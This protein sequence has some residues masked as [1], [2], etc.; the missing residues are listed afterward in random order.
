MRIG[1]RLWWLA[2][3]SAYALYGQEEL[4]T[5][6]GVVTD[7]AQGVMPGVTVTV[8]N[9]DTNISHA[10]VTNES[11]YFTVT[12]LPPGAYELSASKTGFAA[13]RQTG[14]VLE[15]G[16]TLR[17]DV[18]LEVGSVAETVTVR[19]DPAPLNTENGAIKG[20]VIVY[21]EIQDM[22][23]NGRNFTDLTYTVPG[24]V[25]NAQGGSGG[26][27]AV[28]GARGD[29]TSYYVEG[30]G[31]TNKRGTT[32]HRNFPPRRREALPR[33]WIPGTS[34]W[35]AAARILTGGTSSPPF[36]HSNCRWAAEGA[37]CLMPDAC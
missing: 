11:G 4:A 25:A 27:I 37:C 33:P 5:I 23:L 29:S 24:V 21:S 34:G 20:D 35:S 3:F 7:P 2:L 30:F 36:F 15:T 16:Q 22:P 12:D 19:A 8:R 14:I 13:Y 10:L 18:R 9:T 6:T 1:R 28:N 17:S 32:M 31:D 26:I